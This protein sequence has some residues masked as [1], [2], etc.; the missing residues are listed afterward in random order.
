MEENCRGDQWRADKGMETRES[1][2]S[3]KGGLLKVDSCS[4]GAGTG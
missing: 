4:G 2:N 1:E 3:R